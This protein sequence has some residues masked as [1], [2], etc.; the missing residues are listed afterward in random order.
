MKKCEHSYSKAKIL[1]GIIIGLLITIGVIIYFV[2]IYNVKEIKKELI[3]ELQDIRDENI[4]DLP[5]HIQKEITMKI[6]EIESDLSKDKYTT[7]SED[8]KKLEDKI[9][10]EII[11]AQNVKEEKI[12]KEVEELARKEAEEIAKKEREE[13]KRIEDE[14]SKNKPPFDINTAKGKAQSIAYWEE[15]CGGDLNTNPKL[16]EQA[17]GTVG[18]LDCKLPVQYLMPNEYNGNYCVICG[19][20]LLQPIPRIDSFED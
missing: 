20:T 15:Y 6:E 4:N 17:G 16:F 14:Q 5:E 2:D 18:C 13:A 9:K 3:N 1:I 12:K 8:I 19:S 7:T 11:K 10:D